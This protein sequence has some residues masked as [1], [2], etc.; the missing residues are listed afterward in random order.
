MPALNTW[1]GL[2]PLEDIDNEVF[3]EM[4]ISHLVVKINYCSKPAMPE[5]LHLIYRRHLFEVVSNVTT[6]LDI[7][8]GF[9]NEL[10][11][12]KKPLY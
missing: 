6:L 12:S 2:S 3:A 5:I 9:T 8:H 10:W 1:H 11:S 4:S 7:L